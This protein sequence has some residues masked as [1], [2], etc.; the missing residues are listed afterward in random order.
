MHK[1]S[2]RK[3]TYTRVLTQTQTHTHTRPQVVPQSRV[4]AGSLVHCGCGVSYSCVSLITSTL[5]YTEGQELI[6]P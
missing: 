1:H 5:R 6:K 2:K 3:H 4:A